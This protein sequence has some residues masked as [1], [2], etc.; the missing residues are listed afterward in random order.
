MKIALIQ[1]N[2]L[3]GDFRRNSKAVLERLAEARG[4][5]CELAIFPELTLCG[6][7]PRDLLER[8][9]FLL[10][11]DSELERL[12]NRVSGIG[13]IIGA[14]ERR[15]SR[16]GKSL[17]NSALL[18]EEGKVR[19]RARKRLLPAYDVF[20]ETRY[21]EPGREPGMT[22]PYRGLSLALTVCEDIWHEEESYDIDPLADLI[23]AAGSH[24]PDLII[25][26]SASPY[27]TGKF[28]Q[29]CRVFGRI[30]QNRRLP[31]LYVNQVGGQ[32]SLLFDGRS[33]VLDG[34][35][36]VRA[37]AAGFSEDMLIVDTDEIDALSISGQG[38]PENELVDVLD[39]LT[40]GV[41]DYLHKSGFTSAVLGLSGGIDS[42]LT[43]AIAVR[44]LGAD[45]VLCVALPSPYTAQ[46]SIDDARRLSENLGCRF[47]VIPID[48]VFA[49]Y[50]NC[51][52]DLFS[53]LGEDVTEQNIQARIRG[54]LLMAISN[55][56]GHLLL[57]TGNKSEMAVGYCTLYG[58]MNGGL[59]VISDVPKQMVYELAD[60]LNREREIIPKRIIERP[61]SAELKPDQRDD[62]DLPPY[63]VLDR[64]LEA[65]LE[66]NLGIDEI[67]ERG[68]RRDDVEDVIR[69]IKRNEY[70]RQQAPL[71]LKVTSKA[72]GYG[73]RYPV[74]QNFVE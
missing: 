50:R 40:M 17:Y 3:V 39:A 23:H 46:M 26:I 70:K 1:T 14:L 55:K 43:A 63:G 27:Q 45:N 8:R 30:C 19:F 73:R 57:A 59:A 48:D 58:D 29:R 42:A 38:P 5:G 74:V 15:R 18:V 60:L 65:Y 4:A 13:L 32:D 54:S 6:Y 34:E 62:D 24:P 66:E 20:D 21:F 31:L 33:M 72:F 52:G 69:R 25:N 61:P 56:F 35:G 2:P 22:I 12:I 49:A 37:L 36:N 16:R 64:I 68:F 47:R 10:A 44:A 71:G 9:A 28:A 67:V 53:G 11:H 7:P 51:L 41:A